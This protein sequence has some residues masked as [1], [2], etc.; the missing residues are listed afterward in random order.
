M[1][2]WQILRKNLSLHRRKIVLIQELKPLDHHRHREFD[3]E[4][5]RKR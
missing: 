2:T 5:T 4:T 3:D 1:I